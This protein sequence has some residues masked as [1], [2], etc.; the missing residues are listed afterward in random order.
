MQ[1]KFRSHSALSFP[2][3][4]RGRK[5]LVNFFDQGNSTSLFT[6]DDALLASK[7]RAHKWFREGRITE[8]SVSTDTVQDQS[9]HAPA[10]T[11]AQPVNV[12]SRSMSATPYQAPS[13]DLSG[14]GW[15]ANAPDS[16]GMGA[17]R[18]DSDASDNEDTSDTTSEVVFDGE[19]DTA[20][21]DA[22]ET[23]TED[24]ASTADLASQ[25]AQEAAAASLIVPADT[26][27]S[28]T[29]AKEFFSINFG[30]DRGFIRSKAVVAE[31]CAQYNVTFQNYPL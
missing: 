29:E 23:D 2:V 21:S 9:L 12:V 5:Q 1:Y 6:T 13:A 22:A 16:L 4:H 3:V 31:L 17:K 25:E 10:E 20:A 15:S 14:S 27:S 19:E 24:A 26:V 28:L 18:V 30:V 7:I 8:E 11:A